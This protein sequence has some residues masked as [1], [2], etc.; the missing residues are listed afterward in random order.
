[1]QIQGGMPQ[2][3]EKSTPGRRATTVF[4]VIS[5]FRTNALPDAFAQWRFNLTHPAPGAWSSFVGGFRA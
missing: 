1:M 2:I 5:E 4:P 3:R